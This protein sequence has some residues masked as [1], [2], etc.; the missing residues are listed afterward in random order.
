MS[1]SLVSAPADVVIGVAVVT[2]PGVVAVQGQPMSQD[3]WQ[4]LVLCQRHI[5]NLM[6]RCL[7][8]YVLMW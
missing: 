1:R 6:G 8:T 5:D 2:G 3:A 4:S 7:S